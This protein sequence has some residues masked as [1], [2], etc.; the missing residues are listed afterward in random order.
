MSRYA[1][2]TE[3][4]TDRSLAEIQSTVRRYGAEGFM[5]GWEHGDEGHYAMVQFRAAERY[6][7]FLLPLPDPG[8]DE[9]K[10]TP[11][12]RQLR[13]TEQR[14]KAYEQ[15][16]RQRWRA[17][18]LAIKAKLEAV[19]A[20][21]A[22]FEEEFLAHIVLPDGSTV[23]QHVL[24]KVEAAYLTGQMPRAAAVARGGPRWRGRDRCRGDAVSGHETE[25][26]RRALRLK[27]AR[28]E[29]RLLRPRV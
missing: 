4:S 13:S 22:T 18:A 17:L 23:G 27:G 28:H 19:E 10:R 15:A 29:N 5:T 6:V 8:A 2:N 25:V 16:C 12:K 21:I 1:A 7:R 11:A 26:V 24:P 20:G 14:Q 3:V 9:F